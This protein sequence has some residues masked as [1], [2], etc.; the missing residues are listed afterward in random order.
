M[1]GLKNNPYISNELMMMR[2]LNG[3][4]IGSPAQPYV[5]VEDFAQLGSS[6]PV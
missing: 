1:V 4:A 5:V 3:L 2:F 6:L